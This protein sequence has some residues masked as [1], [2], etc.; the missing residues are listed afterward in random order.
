MTLDGNKTNYLDIILK[1][2]YSQIY[3]AINSAQTNYYTISS[4][5]NAAITP[6]NSSASLKLSDGS[7]TA[8]GSSS[9]T[10][11][12]TSNAQNVWAPAVLLIQLQQ[13]M[14]Y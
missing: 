9:R 10:L 4:I 7:T 3:A 5:N 12:F 1:H 6:H 8:S 13:Q 14:V 11:R 2:Q